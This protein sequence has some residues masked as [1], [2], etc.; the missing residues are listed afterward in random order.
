MTAISRS[1]RPRVV[2]RKT[3]RPRK[4]G[5]TVTGKDLADSIA[6]QRA[7]DVANRGREGH[8][9]ISD[10]DFARYA[11]PFG[12]AKHGQQWMDYRNGKR[13]MPPRDKLI[14]ALFLE[15]TP[16][17]VFPSWERAI[18]PMLL[19]VLAFAEQ[20]SVSHDAQVNLGA[21]LQEIAG[22]PP[23]RREV[24]LTKIRQMLNG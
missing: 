11:R 23:A 16:E 1:P 19:Q 3:P 18:L 20:M 17:S 13:H 7:I 21:L 2:D 24:V 8:D 9:R 14:G 12:G 6:F 22:A 10:N 4:K 15:K 5:P